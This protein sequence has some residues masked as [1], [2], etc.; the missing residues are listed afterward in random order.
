[1]LN[2]CSYDLLN[3]SKKEGVV[4]PSMD[5]RFYMKGEPI[6]LTNEKAENG[7]RSASIGWPTGD[8][9]WSAPPH[10]PQVYR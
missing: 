2:I 1:M 6:W 5:P 4:E 8:V 7:R 9:L 3:I 10:R